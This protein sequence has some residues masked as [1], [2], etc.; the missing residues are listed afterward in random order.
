MVRAVLQAGL[1]SGHHTELPSARGW[2]SQLWL[3]PFPSLRLRN[4]DRSFMHVPPPHFLLC[5]ISLSMFSL[6]SSSYPAFGLPC[7]FI[8]SSPSPLLG[9]TH[10]NTK[11][12]KSPPSSHGHLTSAHA[13]ALQ[14]PAS[15]SRVRIC[16]RLW[17]T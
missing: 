8:L 17:R 15:H 5:C 13:S 12:H 4:S 2:G 9:Y 7:P 11:I 3:S 14:F 10:N 1:C 16:S 6:L